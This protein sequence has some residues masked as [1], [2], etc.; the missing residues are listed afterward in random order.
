M[1][2]EIIE[3]PDEVESDVEETQDD[4]PETDQDSDVDNNL[5]ADS[6]SETPSEEGEKEE[7]VDGGES[8]NVSNP[9]GPVPEWAEKRFKRERRKQERLEQENATLRQQT[10]QLANAVQQAPAPGGVQFDPNIHIV[11]PVTGA[12]EFRDSVQ[13][14]VIETLQKR[15]QL[16]RQREEEQKK[17]LQT[18]ELKQRVA[19]GYDKYDDYEDI[20]NS[21]PFTP[22]MLDAAS[23][24]DHV[25]DFIYSLGKNRF[26]DVERI[27]K[28]PPKIQFKEMVK[29]ELEF[30]Q[31]KDKKIVKP[32][33]K[34]PTDVRGS[35]HI[36]KDPA[37][38]SFEEL[39]Q[40]AKAKEEAKYKRR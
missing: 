25:D 5:E 9:A 21:L 38:M 8:K 23:T 16:T 7:T 17:Q 11:D 40:Q 15:E 4:T 36:E 18:Q 27:S 30:E 1:T 12:I 14:Q 19:K 26:E 20:V 6:E 28:L 3:A 29:L 13:G 39:Y 37:K 10:V 32:V 22:E 35:T 24:S 33:P 31:S 34:P 2:D